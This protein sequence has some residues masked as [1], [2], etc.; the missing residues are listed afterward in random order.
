LSHSRGL[1]AVAEHGDAAG[2]HEARVQIVRREHKRA[3]PLLV[4]KGPRRKCENS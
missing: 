2:F 1:S 4:S 3:W